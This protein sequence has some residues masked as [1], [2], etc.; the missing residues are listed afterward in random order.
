[1][2]EA[3]FGTGAPDGR[4]TRMRRNRRDAMRA[5]RAAGEAIGFVSQRRQTGLRHRRDGG[6]RPNGFVSQNAAAGA[7]ASFR[8]EV[9]RV[10]GA[11]DHGPRLCAIMLCQ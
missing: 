11:A 4:D 5:L 3:A 7:L 6:R 8:M 2:V 9:S 1:M 10:A